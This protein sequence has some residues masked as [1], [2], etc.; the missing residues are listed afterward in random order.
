M[1]YYHLLKDFGL[2]K[3]SLK[4][5]FDTLEGDREGEDEVQKLLDRRTQRYTLA[6]IEVLKNWCII[7]GHDDAVYDY[8]DDYTS[9]EVYKAQQ[10]QETYDRVQTL[11]NKLRNEE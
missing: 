7:S 9:I 6:E 2:Y 3:S 8:P 11:I 4:R 10:N 5:K 1:K